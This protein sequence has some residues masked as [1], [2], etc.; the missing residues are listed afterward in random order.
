MNKKALQQIL[1]QIN[2]SGKAEHVCKACFDRCSLQRL[3]GKTNDFFSKA[4][5]Y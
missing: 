2:H 1:E 4:E 5:K 3:Q